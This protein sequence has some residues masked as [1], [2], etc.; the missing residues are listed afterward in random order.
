MATPFFQYVP[1]FEYVSRLPGASLGQYITVKNIFRRAKINPTIFNNLTNFTKYK[2]IGDERPDQVAYKIYG[3]QYYDWVVLLS[4]NIINT[5]EEWP[6]SQQTFSN[7]MT[8]K[9]SNEGNFNSVHHYETKQIKDTA[10]RTML[11][12]GLTV[13]SDFTFQY[14]DTGAM[15]AKK[16]ILTSVSNYEYEESIQRQKRNIFL[17]QPRYINIAIE[18]LVEIMR[19]RKGSTQYVK[20]N[21][22]RGDDVRI[23]Q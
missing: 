10:G 19:Y 22:V 3:S 5:I 6:M 18:N 7:Y 9:Y 17:L 4:N 13:P 16:D 15:V 12:A 23:Y 11:P 2:I 21:L 14:S 1:D 8:Q 20:A